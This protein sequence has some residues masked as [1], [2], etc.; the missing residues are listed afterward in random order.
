[1]RLS[2][3]CLFVSLFISINSF[4]QLRLP[5][6]IS[7]GMVIQQNDL[8]TFWGWGYNGQQVKI[9][10]SWD[11][12]I[13][14]GVVNNNGKWSFPVKTPGAGGP[15][16]ITVNSGGAQIVLNDVMIGEVWL[17]SGQS[18]MEWSYYNG[19]RYIKEEFPTCYNRNIRFFQ[20]PRAASDYPQDDLEGQWKVCDSNSLRSFSAV[21]YFFG[22]KLQHDLNVPIGLINSSWGGTPAE[23]WTPVESINSNDT[24]RKAASELKEVPWGPV[25]VGMLYNGMIAPITKFNIAGAIWY[26]GEANV[27]ANSTYSRLLAT[28][29]DSWR[30]KWNKEFPFYLVQIAPYKYGNKNE[31]A[32]LQ[33]Q[34]TKMMNHPNTGMV[35]IT[36][37]ID[38]V[39]NIHPSDKR[40]VGSRLANWALAETYDKHTGPYISPLLKTAEVA[41]DKIILSFSEIPNGLM[42]RGKTITGFFISGEKEEWLPAE[43]KIENNKIIVWNKTLKQPVYVRYGFGNTL[44]G[45]VFSKE[46]LPLTPFRTDNW[47]VDQGPEKN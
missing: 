36:D 38:S 3:Y 34:Q 12:A 2:L 39:T 4:S 6:V 5:S 40:Y 1:M 45:N 31:G 28:M 29:I 47:P 18:N 22:K 35:V 9:T 8:V 16:T 11:N 7:P 19:A 44:V 13:T 21:G 37:L 42:A 30:A 20:V 27:G 33:E 10:G 15:Y 25:K 46:G 24:L 43:A 17:C 32:L 23:T 26:Q 41:K 14:T